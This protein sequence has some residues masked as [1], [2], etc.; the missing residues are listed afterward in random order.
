MINFVYSDYIR[1]QKLTI[2]IILHNIFFFM[3]PKMIKTSRIITLYI[4][5]KISY[6]KFYPYFLKTK[7][8]VPQIKISYGNLIITL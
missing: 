4:L 2:S 6:V 7:S 8:F 3:F 5:I 1:L